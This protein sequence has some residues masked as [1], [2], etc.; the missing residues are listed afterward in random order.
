MKFVVLMFASMM[1]Y[2]CVSHD[3]AYY[4]LH[5]SA[6]QKAMNQCPEKAPSKVTCKQLRQLASRINELSDELRESP[7][8]FGQQILALQAH[9]SDDKQ[10]LKKNPNQPELVV[11]L[12]KN[13]L[14]LQERL[15]VVKWLESPKV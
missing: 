10:S 5:I 2:A 1:S 8:G 14:V 11:S 13:Q 15:A 9:L 3:E 4:R 7:Q 12:A 6:L